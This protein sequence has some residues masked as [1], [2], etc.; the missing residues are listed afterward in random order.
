M[1]ACHFLRLPGELRNRIYELAL[2]EPNGIPLTIDD[3]TITSSRRTR[4]SN[5]DFNFAAKSYAYSRTLLLGLPHTCRRIRAETLKIYYSINELVLYFE[6]V[7]VLGYRGDVWNGENQGNQLMKW[8]KMIGVDKAKEIRKLR[9]DFGAIEGSGQGDLCLELANSFTTSA[10]KML[11]LELKLAF[12]IDFGRSYAKIGAP[13]STIKVELGDLEAGKEEVRGAARLACE[14][15]KTMNKVLF[16][17]WMCVNGEELVLLSFL[18][19]I[20]AKVESH[21]PK[22][23]GDTIKDSKD[24]KQ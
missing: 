9:L 18:G 12:E 15:I 8:C 5:D 3:H 23:A 2:L 20:P 19:K 11:H 17:L 7:Q 4:P 14:Q 24:D 13:K 1:T 16:S 21:L 6:G 10:K 22:A